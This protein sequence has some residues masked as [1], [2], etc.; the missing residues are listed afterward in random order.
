MDTKVC[1]LM[2]Q[3]KAIRGTSRGMDAPDAWCGLARIGKCSSVLAAFVCPD[4][5]DRH[6]TTTVEEKAGPAKSSGFTDRLQVKYLPRYLRDSSGGCHVACTESC[7][8]YDS[9]AIPNTFPAEINRVVRGSLYNAH[10]KSN[11]ERST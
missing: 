11:D 10:Q 8:S 6:V 7:S 5:L 3:A 2:R 9:T 4:E 1:K